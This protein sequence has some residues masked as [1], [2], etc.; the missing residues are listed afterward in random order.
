[1]RSRG[2]GISFEN[3]K[4]HHQT[5]RE[6]LERSCRHC[7]VAFLVAHRTAVRAIV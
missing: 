5:G 2:S 1:M 4:Q 7:H 3:S 6:G